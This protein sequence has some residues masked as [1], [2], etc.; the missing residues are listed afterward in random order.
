MSRYYVA[1]GMVQRG[2]FSLEDLPG[3]GLRPDVLV[4][5]D[6]M[7][8]WRR[9]D[10]VAEIIFSG[11]LPKPLPSPAP[12]GL[13]AAPAHFGGYQP[14]YAAPSYNPANSNRVAAGVCGIFL[15]GLG[16][17][18]FILG[19]PGTGII[20]LLLN[21]VGGFLTCGLASIVMHAIGLIEGILYLTKRDE[22]FHQIYVVQK[23]HWF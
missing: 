23:R 17:H 20:M 6:G 16:I 18:K 2:P 4:W 19:M 12:S 21:L 13:P 8:D 14:I 15:G 9:A 5:K 11:L 22:E 1:D 3:Q 7:D 10:Q